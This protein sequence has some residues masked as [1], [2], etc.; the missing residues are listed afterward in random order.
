MRRLPIVLIAAIVLLA[1]AFRDA[2]PV[3]AG[4]RASN[5]PGVPIAQEKHHHLVLENAY[6]KVYEVEV[7]PRHATLISSPARSRVAVE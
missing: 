4:E 7:G 5:L 2:P 1:P 3:S 6:V